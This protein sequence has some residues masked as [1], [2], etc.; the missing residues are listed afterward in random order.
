MLEQLAGVVHDRQFAAGADAR[1][2]ADHRQRAG[3]RR[4]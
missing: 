2:D 4:Q 3:R 1:V